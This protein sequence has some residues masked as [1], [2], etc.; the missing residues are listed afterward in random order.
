MVFL[1]VVSMGGSGGFSASD[2][3]ADAVTGAGRCLCCCESAH[4]D[5]IAA[6]SSVSLCSFHAAECP[7]LCCLQVVALNDETA[8]KFPKGDA[9]H[10]S[11]MGNR[12]GGFF[13]QLG[14][15][16]LLGAGLLKDDGVAGILGIEKSTGG[17]ANRSLGV[18]I[19]RIGLLVSRPE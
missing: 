6:A 13:L 3:A 7:P 18:E 8:P 4:F 12:T 17:A 2:S 1:I 10:L 11:P 19:L 5:G 9:V 16:R 15:T 14:R